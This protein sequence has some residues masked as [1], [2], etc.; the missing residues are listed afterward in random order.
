[1]QFETPLFFDHNR[2]KIQI[3]DIDGL[4]DI[5]SFHGEEGLSQPYRY[6]IE[7]TCAQHDIPA[8]RLLGKEAR[9]SLYPPPTPVPYI[10]MPVPA[11]EPLRTLYGVITGYRRL[12]ASADETRY[13]VTLQPRLALLDRGR[14]CRV[15]LQKSVP[16]IVESVFRSER[17]QWA[18]QDFFFQL[19]REYPT[20]E[21]TLQIGESDLAFVNRL[22]AEVGIWYRF[23]ANEKLRIDVVELHDDQRAYERGV[24][25]PYQPQS[26]TSSDG[27]D[28]V[29]QLQSSHGVVEQN[30]HFLSYDY[31]DANA[32][33]QGEVDQSRGDPTTYG[34]AY[35]YGENYGVL[36]NAYA[37]DENLQS[38]S[39]FFYGRLRHE[40]YLNQ[41]TRLGGITSSA[42][43]APG[44]VLKVDG[45]PQAFAPGA[46]I[47]RVVTRAARDSSFIAS[48]DG[49]PYSETV[50]F[51][52]PLLPKPII[53]GTIPARVTSS[54]PND[55]YS[56]I[57]MQGRYKVRFLFDREAASWGDGQESAWLRLARPY[58]GDAH[59]LH[60][61]LI[62]GTEV[63]IAFEQ[64]DIDKAFIAFALHDSRHTDVITLREY[65]RNRLRT[66][67]DN[68]LR[69]E[70]NRGREHVHLRSPHSGQ[71]QLNLG[72]L[73]T[74]EMPARPRGAGFEL[75]TDAHGALR[76]GK[77][78]L[79]S[80]DEQTNGL[81]E[82]LDMQ[83]AESLLKGALQQMRERAEVAQ[84]HH[85]LKP[86]TKSLAAFREA[87]SQLSQPAMLLSA[88][89]GIGVLSP[90]SLL[91]ASS[92]ALYLQSAGEV[93]L[94]S[95]GCM[96][97]H[98]Q[99]AISLLAQQEGMRLV[100]GKGPLEVESHADTL[101]L[102]ALKDITLQSVE[103]HLQITAKK[104][105]TLASGGAYIHLSPEGE[106]QIHGPTLLSLKGRHRWQVPT[107]Q[108]FPLPEL[109]SSVCKECLKRAREMQEGFANREASA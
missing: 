16:E 104:G 68:E 44:Q 67:A 46:V 31:R 19:T 50:C 60:L 42:A 14:Q 58:G 24:S 109:P 79:I 38:E 62:Q 5:V 1:M 35:H 95:N 22:L 92:K 93:N 23:T 70:D 55:L 78:L 102:T 66:P 21:Q 88:P 73:V 15:Y 4:L 3:Q 57:D 45:A 10:G 41:Q 94:A 53:A 106:I 52:P 27:H 99:Q 64:G 71:S 20:R 47:T 29:W 90:Q 103:G 108:N 25:L 9:F 83:P 80:A 86:D 85:N 43:L 101:A 56:H 2:H 6:T 96:A 84:A 17:H 98:S 82:Q 69:I 11:S 48:F 61:P 74:G 33:L 37:Q 12:A 77:G 49:I 105:I 107:R 89:R 81:G 28:A 7:L 54:Q 87:A 51:R 34:E 72:H 76:A 13:E 65:K 97:A 8:D 40:R 32:W 59:G 18:G 91:L 75:R 100:S 63:A 36:G 39:G 30:V 26:G